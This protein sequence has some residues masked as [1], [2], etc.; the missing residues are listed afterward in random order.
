MPTTGSS[1]TWRALVRSCGS[2]AGLAPGTWPR[3][4]STS[5]SPPLTSVPEPRSDSRVALSVLTAPCTRPRSS[6]PT[7]AL[8]RSIA[9]TVSSHWSAGAPWSV[10]RAESSVACAEPRSR[11]ASRIDWPAARTSSR[12]SIAAGTCPRISPLSCSSASS[13]FPSPSGRSPG[14]TS[15]EGGHLFV[16]NPGPF[17]DGAGPLPEL[18]RKLGL[19]LTDDAEEARDPLDGDREFV[20]DRRRRELVDQRGERRRGAGRSPSGAPGRRSR[21]IVRRSSRA[22]AT[23]RWMYATKSRPGQLDRL[24]VGLPRQLA[25]LGDPF[26][27]SRRG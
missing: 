15:V 8:A 25:E 16:R 20:G 27:E 9:G 12:R 1:V 18:E 19:G 4:S 13:T 17:G 7:S 11:A 10:A 3:S 21:T 22:G 6:S 5:T 23:D 14:G 2:S 26:G 24:P